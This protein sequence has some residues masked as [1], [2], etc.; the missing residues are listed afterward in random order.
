MALKT[1]NQVERD[2]YTLIRES[3]L[4]KGIRG[5]V[6]RPDMRPDDA[7]TEDLVLK[8]LAGL[9][10]QIQS[11]VIIINLYVPD[12]PSESGRKVK[13]ITRI[14]V[15]EELIKSF[16]EDNDNTEYIISTEATPT[17]MKNNEIEQH[18]IYARIKF[19][20]ATF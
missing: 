1:E 14:G 10:D 3:S 9:D 2:F 6:Y 4:G 12:I 15:L 16:V 18:F 13:D 19:K 8:F 20:R 7:K 11:G 5:K 17:S